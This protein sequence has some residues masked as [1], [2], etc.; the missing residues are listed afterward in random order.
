V[1]VPGFSKKERDGKPADRRYSQQWQSN[2]SASYHAHSFF[3]VARSFTV[4]S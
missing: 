1:S 4:T 2:P 3:F